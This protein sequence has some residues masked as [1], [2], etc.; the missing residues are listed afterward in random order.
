MDPV[1]GLA[2]AGGLS[3]ASGLRLYATVFAVGMLGKFH[4]IHLPPGLQILTHP[5]VFGLAGFLLFVEFLADKF[6]GID[7][8]W[9]AAH[10]FIRI[11]AGALLAW[12]AIDSTDPL[13][14]ACAVLLGGTLAGATHFAKAGGRALINTSPEPM[15]NWAASFGEEGLFAL[16]LWAALAHPLAFLVGL[17]V[18]VLFLFWFLPK[19]W[20]SLG[21]IVHK[22]RGLLS[23]APST[24]VAESETKSP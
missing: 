11:P 20:R 3:W 2:L 17:A 8:L 6:P 13:V 1:S 21:F 10:T 5:A 9:D 14:A 24:P 12:G 4:Y 22:V 19:V 23:P 18:F 16:G 15:S 7:S